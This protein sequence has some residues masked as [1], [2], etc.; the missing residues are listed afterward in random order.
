ML[1]MSY[2]FLNA[3]ECRQIV[4]NHFGST[5]SILSFR[6]N[7]FIRTQFVIAFRELARLIVNSFEHFAF[8]KLLHLFGKFY[9]NI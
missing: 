2:T 6:P 8:V 7:G 1:Y 4:V 5:F 9:T 3:F